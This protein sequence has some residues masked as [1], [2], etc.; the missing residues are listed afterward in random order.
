MNQSHIETLHP[1]FNPVCTRKKGTGWL[2]QL[3]CVFLPLPLCL[4]SFQTTCTD[5]HK[6]TKEMWWWWE[7]KG[8]F[9]YTHGFLMTCSVDS[10]SSLTT[11]HGWRHLL[12]EERLPAWDQAIMLFFSST[13]SSLSVC[14]PACQPACWGSSAASSSACE[15][16]HQTT[17]LH[18]PTPLHQCPIII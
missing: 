6:N 13:F 7:K 14:L 17:H 2:V 15:S 3:S 9:F 12:K 10:V 11:M 4:T 8:I 1:T 18:P 16:T 5:F